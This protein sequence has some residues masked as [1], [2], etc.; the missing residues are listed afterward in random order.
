MKRNANVNN[1]IHADIGLRHGYTLVPNIVLDDESISNN[2]QLVYAHILKYGWGKGHCYP[3]HETLAKKLKLSVRSIIRA[4][5][6]LK[7]KGLISWKQRGLNKTNIYIIESLSKAYKNEEIP[8]SDTDVTPVSHQDMTSMSLQDMPPM[9]DKEYKEVKN[10]KIKNI[11]LTFP[12]EADQPL[13]ENVN[14]KFS[15]YSEEAVNLAKELNDLKS[16]NYYQKLISQKDKGEI[17]PEDISDSLDFVRIQIRTAQVD[18]TKGLKNPAGLFVK[19]LKQL[20]EKRKQKKRL[21]RID[22]MKAK[23]MEKMKF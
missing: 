5:N 13:A 4:L 2:A 11:K 6:E 8:L 16:L 21:V 19:T 15:S 23:L 18:G 20:K 7:V 3:G 22:E 14:G 10:I 9:S 12:P 1:I 17:N